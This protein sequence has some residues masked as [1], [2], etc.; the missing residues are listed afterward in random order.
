MPP[1]RFL[2]ATTAFGLAGASFAQTGF[3]YQAAPDAPTSAGRI[4]RF[5]SA[6]VPGSS[7]SFGAEFGANGGTAPSA[8][9]VVLSDGADPRTS[10]GTR[11]TF[12]FDASAFVP[13]LTALRFSGEG[14]LDAFLSGSSSCEVH[15]PELLASSVA[16]ATFAQ[17]MTS[18]R[19]GD[20]RTLGFVAS[21]AGLPNAGY[22]A[23]AGMWLRPLSGVSSTYGADGTI[24]A[25]RATKAGSYVATNAATAPVPEPATLAVLGLGALALARRK[26]KR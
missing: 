3:R 19:N 21:T 2:A 24:T 11:T 25:F 9:L 16:S 8:F 4:E 6:F 7:L 18:R 15:R 20:Q 22:G 14:A 17:E 26:K 1:K 5:E 23:R 10:L 13:K 12:L